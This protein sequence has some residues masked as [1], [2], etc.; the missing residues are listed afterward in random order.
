MSTFNEEIDATLLHLV[1]ECARPSLRFRLMFSASERQ[2][3]GFAVNTFMSKRQENHLMSELDR[4]YGQPNV[5]RPTQAGANTTN[6]PSGTTA[7]ER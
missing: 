7:S 1:L 3:I 2:L 4:R 5:G 6:A